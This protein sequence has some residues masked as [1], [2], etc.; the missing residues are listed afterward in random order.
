MNDN[1]NKVGGVPMIESNNVVL[2][3]NVMFIIASLIIFLFFYI[4]GFI[5]SLYDLVAFGIIIISVTPLATW[6]A[7]NVVLVSDTL[8]TNDIQSGLFGLVFFRFANQ[9]VWIVI[10]YVVLSLL[11][12]IIKRPLI[13]RFPLKLDRRLDKGLSMILSGLGIF[14]LGTLITGMILSPVF[15]NG[16]DIVDQSV[17]VIFKQSGQELVND[18][19]DNVGEFDIVLRL[20]EGES[21]NL[22]D[23]QAIID[24]FVS[25]EVP[26]QFATTISKFALNL[27][28]S[29]EEINVL[30]EY[31]QQQGLTLDDLKALLKDIGLSQEIIDDFLKD[32]N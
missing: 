20:L 25:L 2:T 30:V 31:A 5:S 10:V 15:A 27:E 22:D 17:L 3:V 16:S 9:V 14:I 24:L 21:L 18:I 7:S 23:Q 1:R 26:Q 11:F 32:F 28:V 12:L 4:K 6:L 29:R 19:T 13:K 8:S